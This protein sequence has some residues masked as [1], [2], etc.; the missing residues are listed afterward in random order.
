MTKISPKAKLI[1]LG[2][3]IVGI[4]GLHYGTGA[5]LTHHHIFYR[6]LYYL[7][8][9]MGAFWFGVRG[10]LITSSI[11]AILYLPFVLVSWDG[12]SVQ[13][14][15]RLIAIALYYVMALL[16][17]VLRDREK[18]EHKRLV[19]AE[20][21]A[22]IGKALSGVAHDFKTPL[23]AIGGFAKWVQK[24]LKND[25]A[26]YAKLDIVIEETRRLE[27]MV[28]DMLDFSRPLQLNRSTTV[29]LI[30]TI[31]KI[32]AICVQAND[33]RKLRIDIDH[34]RDIPAVSLDPMRMEQALINLLLNAIQ[35][36]PDEEAVSI[37]TYVSSGYVRIEVRDFGD[38]IP[39]E[40]R[41]KIFSPFFTT[42]K[43]GTGLGLPIAK[44]IIEAHG[45]RLEVTENLGKGTV[46]TASLPI[47]T[48]SVRV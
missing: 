1:L 5:G 30:D 36:T 46:F 29:N 25:D 6:E 31:K 24:K 27:N 32:V 10:A 43:E 13:D 38:G 37:S 12:F 42:K 40:H 3:L 4:S 22:A 21:L 7:P 20:N 44:K 41:E 35:V 19:E 16:V 34:A 17:G 48:P 2:V 39:A 14:V 23:I 47:E 28:N 18:A 15:H 11:I 26:C 33:K 45:G 8:L 9:V